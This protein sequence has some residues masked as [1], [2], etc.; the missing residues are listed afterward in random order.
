MKQQSDR[1]LTSLPTAR[2]S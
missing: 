1:K 2:L